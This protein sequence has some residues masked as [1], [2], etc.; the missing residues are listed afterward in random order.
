MKVAPTYL[1]WRCPPPELTVP[2]EFTMTPIPLA[3]FTLF[4]RESDIKGES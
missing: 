3:G 2:Q 4:W 1:F